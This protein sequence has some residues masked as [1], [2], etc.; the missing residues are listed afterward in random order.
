MNVQNL[1]DKKGGEKIIM[2]TAYDYSMAKIIDTC[3]IDLILVG[4]SLGNV[5]KGDMGT[6][7]VS[8]EDVLYHTLAVARGAKK[9]G[10]IGDMPINSDR[11]PEEA[12]RNARRLIEAGAH[13]IKLEGFKPKAIQAILDGGIP[14]M[15]HVGMLPQTAETY[16]VKGKE[17]EDAERILND[18]SRLDELGVFSMVVECVPES[19]ARRITEAVKAVTIS[20]GAGKYCDGQ[21]L[22]LYDILGM[23]DSWAPKFVKKYANLNKTIKDVI[24]QFKQEVVSGTF[25]DDAHTYH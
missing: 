8:I 18:A 12:L 11:T 22:N 4:D 15:G 14:V 13:A 6:K 19:L 1:R 25:P 3:G 17:P 7:N 20:A 23:D 9:T 5:V 2:L 24:A 21:N 16:R 10:I